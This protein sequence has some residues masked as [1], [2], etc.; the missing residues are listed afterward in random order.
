VCGIVDDPPADARRRPE[1]IPL[2]L[3]ISLEPRRPDLEDAI[4]NAHRRLVEF[5]EKYGWGHL[6]AES[7]A[8]R[9]EMFDS[10]EA[11]DRAV[12]EVC[13]LDPLTTLLPTACAALERRVLLSVSPERYAR[14]YPEG[15]EEASF[16]KLLAHEMAHRLHIRILVGD[17]DAMG[18]VWFFEGLAIH[19]A[20]Q[21]QGR[22]PRLSRDEIWEIVR[23]GTRGGY[24]R[25]ASVIGHF[26]KHAELAELVAM[27]GREDFL[28]RLRGIERR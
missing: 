12:I 5:A 13:E 3:P 6:T 1:Q 10:K 21:F 15:I 2:D 14:I 25:Y 20:G 8:D 28:D 27:A 18:P 9:A 4:A 22:A 23:S 16:E 24:P 11:F 26:L 19:A 17:E 7:F